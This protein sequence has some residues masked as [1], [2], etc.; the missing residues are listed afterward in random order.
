MNKHRRRKLCAIKQDLSAIQGTL[1]DI[2]DEE[3]EAFDGF[4]ENLQESERGQAMQ[5][6]VDCMTEALD[7]LEEASDLL[8]SAME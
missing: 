8:A 4:P 5:N 2:L 3:E 6:A 7:Y 1:Q